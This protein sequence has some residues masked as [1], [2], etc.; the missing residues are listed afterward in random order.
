MKS[1]SGFKSRHNHFSLHYSSVDWPCIMHNTTDLPTILN[2][3]ETS[4]YTFKWISDWGLLLLLS[5]NPTPSPCLILSTLSHYAWYMTHERNH[6]I[7][8]IQCTLHTAHSS[9]IHYCFAISI[10][11]SFLTM[12][13]LNANWIVQKVNRVNWLSVIFMMKKRETDKK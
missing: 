7:F 6:T 11:F 4:I 1:W 5:I 10:L 3:I 13:W 9:H 8:I 12:D 2:T